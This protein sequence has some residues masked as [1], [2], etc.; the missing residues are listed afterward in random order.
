MTPLNLEYSR[1][2]KGESV[3]LVH[4][5]ASDYR[6]W[7][8]QIDPLSATFQVVNY[9]RRHHWPN[10]PIAE[11][12]EYSM[13]EQVDDL[14]HLLISLDDGPAHIVGHSYG[15]YLALLV[16]INNPSLVGKLVLAEPPVI[17]LFSDFPPKPHQILKLLLTRP[18]TAIPIIKFAA[19]GLGPAASAARKDDMDSATIHF[20]KA[21]LGVDAFEKLPPTR[22]EQVR[23]NS[24]KA[25]LLSK[26]FMTPLDETDVRN[27]QARTLLVTGEKSPV[28]F[29]RLVDRLEELIPNAERIDVPNASHMMHE[30]NAAAFNNA[31]LSFFQA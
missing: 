21:V 13:S 23:I 3:V 25:E 14:E 20:G 5:S 10:E 27:I 2:G 16:A 18:A 12:A 26:S 1:V 11:G 6:T 7:E 17:P 30:D 4:G 19:K 15:A 24:S 8:Q 31:V 28:M 29:H 9:S 22:M